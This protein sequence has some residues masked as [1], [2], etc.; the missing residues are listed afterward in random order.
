MMK[1]VLRIPGLLVLLG[2]VGLPAASA[3][4]QSAGKPVKTAINPIIASNLPVMIAIEKEIGRAH[5]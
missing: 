3:L 5:V 1:A 2:L 4:A